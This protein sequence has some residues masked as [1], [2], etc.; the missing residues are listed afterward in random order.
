MIINFIKLY[1]HE[2]YSMIGFDITLMN[3][4]SNF[5]C[6]AKLKYL[7]YLDLLYH[8]KQKV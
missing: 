7:L 5:K 1:S 8:L 6:N 4:I 3:L 2:Y